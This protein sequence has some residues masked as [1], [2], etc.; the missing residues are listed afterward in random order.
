MSDVYLWET[1]EK[2][3][4]EALERRDI[5]Q[6]VESFRAAVTLAETLPGE[7]T[8]LVTSLRHLSQ[9]NSQGGQL[10]LAY[11]LLRKT[12]ELAQERL[13][14]GHP[15][16]V[17]IQRDLYEL[18][19]QLGYLE[20]AEHYLAEVLAAVRARGES[21]E[22][23]EILELLAGLAGER[24]RWSDA[25]ELY[26]QLVDARTELHG[27]SD[28]GIA[29]SLLLLSTAQARSG[30]GTHSEESLG[31]AFT[32][33]EQQ[34]ADDPRT[35][36]QSLLAG[37]ELLAASGH[38]DR[39][40]EYQKRALD[41]FTSVEEESHP[42]LWEARECIGA[43]LAGLGQ[44]DEAIEVLE[45]CLRHHRGEKDYRV[46]GLM[47]NLAGLYLT[48]N[49]IDRAEEL[50]EEAANIL[51]NTLGPDHPATLATTEE[52]IQL[53]H[54][55]GR[56]DKALELALTTIRG[57]EQRYGAGHPS[58]AQVYVST[59]L[60]AHASQKWETAY[61]LMKAAEA[62]WETLT[63]VPH[64]VLANGRL[65]LAT[66]L[67]EM[68]RF[69]EAAQ[70]LDQIPLSP[71]HPNTAIVESLRARLP[72]PQKDESPF[73][74]TS[75]E[76]GDPPL[77][78]EVPT[79]ELSGDELSTKEHSQAFG[80]ERRQFQRFNL[81]LNRFFDLQVAEQDGESTAIQSFLVDLSAGGLR[82]NSAAPLPTEHAFSLTLPPDLVGQELTFQAR[83][84]WHRTLFGASYLQGVEFLEAS[85]VQ[86]SQLE[87]ALEGGDFSGAGRQH[88]RLY[89]PFPIEIKNGDDDW[90]STYASDLSL[91][92]LGARLP[93]KL[94]PGAKVRVRL[95]LDFELPTVEVG[96]NVAWSHSSEN[97]FSHGLQFQALEP[98]EAKTIKLYIDRCLELS[99]D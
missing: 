9:A 91:E 71:G 64:D 63:P 54:F 21:V 60:L 45:F 94:L 15:E 87:S 59:A 19:R 33:L 92:G 24:E 46:G 40:L 41:L 84:V 57:T 34:F 72:Q 78:A 56:S 95:R 39:A 43:S 31:K 58:T 93:H 18:A 53:Y 42:S 36:A 6:A 37:A 7:T 99:P 52:R 26:Q 47:K 35:L 5:A 51:S 23:L 70:C 20:Q 62:I 96:A 61:Q 73:H 49:K 81:G 12:E 22:F 85:G 32:L 13:G 17:Q 88:Y 80:T 25:V 68:G 79:E 28:P 30:Q 67:I 90:V 50:Y 74:L 77:V 48:T 3:G 14:G 8:K 98:V 10:S 55:T 89:R 75:R 4:K 97:G 29:Q 1:Y 83:V 66:L 82:V 16:I 65:N 76:E 27:D 44:L 69:D 2:V 86:K 11:D 38:L